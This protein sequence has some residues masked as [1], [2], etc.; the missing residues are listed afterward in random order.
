MGVGKEST[1]IAV[2]SELGRHPMYCYIIQSI[3]RYWHRLENG[4]ESSLLHRAY[5][6]SINLNFHNINCWFKNLKYFKDRIG[7]LL[8]NCKNI[9]F[10]SFKNLR[11]ENHL[12][13]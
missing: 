12:K 7:I 10:S 5:T 2:I 13:A 4:P 6:A 3:L 9:A 11:T 1:N 8:P